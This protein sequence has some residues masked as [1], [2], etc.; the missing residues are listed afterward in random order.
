[1]QLHALQIKDRI[2]ATAD[3]LPALKFYVRGGFRLN[4]FKALTGTITA[5]GE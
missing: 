5:L 2:L 3:V 1:M 4:V